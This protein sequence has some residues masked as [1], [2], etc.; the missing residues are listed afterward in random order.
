MGEHEI[1]LRLHSLR[2]E[3]PRGPRRPFAW[4]RSNGGDWCSMSHATLLCLPKVSRQVYAETTAPG[5]ARGTFTLASS[6]STMDYFET[7]RKWTESLTA[8][9]VDSITD[10]Q[11]HECTMQGYRPPHST[12]D[13]YAPPPITKFLPYLARVHIEWRQDLDRYY[14]KL[15]FYEKHVP[16]NESYLAGCAR[17]SLGLRDRDDVEI[18]YD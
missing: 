11:L 12:H 1:L 18:I 2:P 17:N 6:M 13:Q 16:R 9:H 4:A 8:A 15:S 7:M 14:L 10:L 3:Y 5:Y